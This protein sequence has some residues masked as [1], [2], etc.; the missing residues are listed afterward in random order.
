MAK[1]T[2]GEAALTYAERGWHVFPLG[3]RSKLP[4]Q[5]SH[6]LLDATTDLDQVRAWWSATPEANIGLNCGASGLVVV[7]VDPRHGGDVT[8]A[9]LI[10]ELGEEVAR[11]ATGLTGGGGRHFLFRRNEKD[12]RSLEGALGPGIDTKAQGGYILLPPSVHPDTGRAYAWAE[13]WS[14]DDLDPT[15][16]P[17]ALEAL[18]PEAKATEGPKGP[19]VAHVATDDAGDLWLRRA[20]DRV[21]P[22]TRNA[23][24]FWLAC[25]LR[26]AGLDE[27]AAAAVLGD[28]VAAVGG[29]GGHPYTEAEARKSLDEAYARPARDPARSATA[30]TEYRGEV[31]AVPSDVDLNAFH[32]TDSG[33]AEAFAALYGDR[34]RFAHLPPAK[35]GS[36]AGHFLVW[37]GHRWATAETGEVDRWA[38]LVARAREKAA[39]DIEDLDRRKAALSWAMQ[40][41]S[42]YRRRTTADLVRVTAPVATRFTDYDRDPWVLGCEN[43]VLDLRD[44]TLREGRPADM[45]TKSVGYGFDEDADCPRWRRFLDEVFDGDTALVGFLQRAVGYSLTGDTREQVLF[46]CHG[47][48]SNGK[49]VLLSTL[50]ALLGD[51]ADNT[52]FSTFEWDRSNANTNDVAALVGRRLVTAAETSEARRLNEARVKAVTGGDPV[53]ARFLFSEYFTYVPTYKVFLAMNALPKVVGTDE[54][55]WRRI[56]LVPFR[57]SFKGREDK[58]IGDKLRAELPGILNWA[59]DGCLQWQT[60]GDLCAPTAV[61][62]A[63]AAYRTESDLVG[64]FLGETTMPLETGTVRASELYRAYATW[65]DD[66]GEKPVTGTTFG[67]RLGEKGFDKKRMTDGFY[68]VGLCL[69]ERPALGM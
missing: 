47:T 58:T 45:V 8:W 41:E 69:V 48:G 65:C 43:G 22:G 10:S 12:V 61:V 14:P 33:N 59:L 11:T 37:S 31:R 18:C 62:D 53:T 44:G 54:G 19:P 68:Y 50:R 26:D 20:L 9:G 67:L 64:R 35:G 5:G 28:Y 39:L 15:P 51:Y 17:P 46:L 27:D 52:P 6:G 4:R 60:K 3:A 57:V 30:R 24:G 21:A 34:L 55:I 66:A 40:S 1:E 56:R 36:I 16:L 38:L 49:S 32:W 13:G 63:T 7:D 42:A 29:I 2:L 25:Q 23:T